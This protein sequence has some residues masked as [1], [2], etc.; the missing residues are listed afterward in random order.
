[1]RSMAIIWF[2]AVGTVFAQAGEKT[3]V[4]LRNFCD[5]EVKSAGIEVRQPVTLHIKA[6]G[7]GADYGWTNKT[8]KMYA[9]GW[10]INADSRELVWRM[11]S[12]NSTVAGENRRFDGTLT[13]TPGSY[14]VYFAAWGIVH[15]TTFSQ[16]SMNIDRRKGLKPPPSKKGG[17]W[18]W[19]SEWWSDDLIKA[20]QSRC[21][22][23]GIELG[24]D[25]AYVSAVEQFT[26][27]KALPGTV[28]AVTGIGDGVCKR[29]GFDLAAPTTLSL[30]ALGEG[31]KGQDPVDL[32]WIVDASDRRRVWE[33]CK[34]CDWAG[35]SS[36]NRRSST[37]LELP[38]GAYVLYY[39]SDDS[40]SPDDWN[41]EPPYDPLNWGVTISIAD[42]GE[43]SNFK[44]VPYTEDANV[45]VSLIKV[46]N[47]EYRTAGFALKRDAEVRVYAIGE[48][49]N[50]LKQ[51]ADQGSILDARTREK[52]WT[53]DVDRTSY[54]GG[55]TKNRYIDEVIPLRRGK[56]LV[57]Y[58]SDDSHAYGAWNSDPPCDKERYGITVMGSGPDF[59][60]SIV[61]KF[62]D[63][64]DETII[65]RIAR[66]G[67][68]KDLSKKFKIDRTTRVRIY[69]IG[70][71]QNRTMY[72]YGWIE[73]VKSGNVLWEMT[74]A[75]TF[76]AGGARKNRVV[77]TTIVLDRGEYRLRWR[78]DDS[79]SFGDWNMDPPED[80]QF[81]GIT[82]YYDDI[83]LPLPPMPSQ[84]PN[85]EELAKPPKPPNPGKPLKP[86]KSKGDSGAAQD[87]E[88]F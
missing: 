43:R 44:L 47:D 65:A 73:D 27:P 57:T 41:D 67:D 66:P 59:D 30:Y 25:E 75:M 31:L 76:H 87:Q 52:V 37:T 28:L 83:A 20:W 19:F 58:T 46:G 49:S 71:G 24:I 56:Y 70:E 35:G 7:G 69:A 51:M 63:E 32:G 40:H 84:N 77:N 34:D 82:L 33:M 81:W 80:Q 5:T 17:V 48:R 22:G 29:I 62:V 78:S 88:S 86:P 14:E 53:M 9:Y 23:W 68:D 15:R 60:P 10:I 79:H 38:R 45:I 3:I 18:S 2:I 11:D 16:I 8:S 72:D 6:L 26:P 1:M 54:A 85:T 39:S 36:K 50:S 4:S 42:A 21:S 12:K 74:Y 55:A 61:E 64:G 13:L